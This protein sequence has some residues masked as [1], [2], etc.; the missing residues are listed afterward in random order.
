MA[1]VTICAPVFARLNG[2]DGLVT[3]GEQALRCGYAVE[4]DGVDEG[5]CPTTCYVTVTASAREGGGH[6]VTGDTLVDGVYVA[7]IVLGVAGEAVSAQPCP[8][9]FAGANVAG[10]AFE[11]SVHSG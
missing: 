1:A 10:V 9:A 4:A 5:G 6:R 8:L 11:E 7:A 3:A 2:E